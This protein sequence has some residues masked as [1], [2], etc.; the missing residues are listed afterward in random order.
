MQPLSWDK[1]Q[2]LAESNGLSIN[3]IQ[4]YQ[5]Y[6]FFIQENQLLFKNDSFMSNELPIGANIDFVFTKL[7]SQFKAV[8]FKREPLAKAI[9]LKQNSLLIDATFGMGGDSMYFLAMGLKVN[10]YEREPLIFLI[11]K[12]KLNQL[13]DSIEVFE[14]ITLNFGEVDY[15]TSHE[16]IYYDPMYSDHNE[17]ALPNKQMRI[18]RSVIGIDEDEQVVASKLIKACG[19]L[20]IK[21][22]IKALALLNNPQIQ[23]KGKSTRYDVYLNL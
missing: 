5:R 13:K 18:F 7:Q 12:L 4:K 11:N 6:E 9:G 2:L 15:N 1:F 22:P 10:A 14:K 16:V 3:E 17:K 23:F 21:R 19:R 20:I 8:G